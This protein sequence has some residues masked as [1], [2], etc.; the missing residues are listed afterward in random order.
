MLPI[1]WLAVPVF[2]GIPIF[3]AIFGIGSIRNGDILYMDRLRSVM[4]IPWLWV[5]ATSWTAVFTL[6]GVAGYIF[7]RDSSASYLYDAGIAL[8][9]VS[10][11][12]T[13]IW[14]IL[15]RTK[16]NV[17]ASFVVLLIGAC[18]TS[19]A[20]LVIYGVAENWISF[21]VYILVPVAYFFSVIWSGRIAFGDAAKAAEMAAREAEK[22]PLT[23]QERTARDVYAS[24]NSAIGSDVQASSSGNVRNRFASNNGGSGNMFFG[25]TPMV[26]S[27]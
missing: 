19:I 16:T 8:S 7:W 27:K 25:A 21:G 11:L 20:T 22:M 26:G 24:S 6:M 4:L 12:C 3:F 18:C 9:W 23:D 5:L 15:A 14:L 2:V 1:E 10:F 17:I 13:G